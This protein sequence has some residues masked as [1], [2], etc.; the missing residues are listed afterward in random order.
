[1]LNSSRGEN[2]GRCRSGEGGGLPAIRMTSDPS[3]PAALGGREKCEYHD[4]LD[5]KEK[6]V[7][8][9]CAAIIR[10]P[11]KLHRST[12]SRL[13][14]FVLCNCFMYNASNHTQRTWSVPSPAPDDIT[15]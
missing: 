9:T 6:K 14:A 15:E 12:R 2:Y 11:S 7:C 5:G 3:Y 4:K 10:Y 1:M 13:T 8:I